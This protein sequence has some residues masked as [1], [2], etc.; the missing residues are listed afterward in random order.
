MKIGI[1]GANG[2]V[3]GALCRSAIKKNCDF[4]QV[5]RQN[6]QENKSEE[7]DIL[8]NS[9]MPSKRYWASSHPLEDFDAS[10][11]LT[12]ELIYEWK[13]KKFIQISS[14]EA[15]YNH[16]PYAVNKRSAEIIVS[17][18]KSSLIVRL[19]ALYGKGLNKGALYDLIH[20]NPLYVDID[21]VYNYLDTDWC[22]DWIMN[23]LDKIGLIE[24]GAKDTI[25]LKEIADK[26]GIKPNCQGERKEIVFTEKIPENMPS[27]YE[28][29]N[30]VE[31]QIKK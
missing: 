5:T 22:A 13:Y 19:C 12:A 16:I 6:F 30:F 14:I 29:L 26:F 7:F 31:K 1:V 11:R 25:T 24:I 2:F 8:I 3:G 18:I 9:A 21:S 4:I 10:V 20:N 27:A 17:L 28:V 23:N 15:N